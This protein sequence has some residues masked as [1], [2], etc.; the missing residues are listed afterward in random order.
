M[1]VTPGLTIQFLWLT[2]DSVGWTTWNLEFGFLTFKLSDSDGESESL[3]LVP[4]ALSKSGSSAGTHP[5][6][7]LPDSTR[8]VDRKRK[9]AGRS[10]KPITSFSKVTIRARSRSHQRRV[11][12][13][14]RKAGGSKTS[15]TVHAT[16]SQTFSLVTN[17]T[18]S[19]LQKTLP[20]QPFLDQCPI[21]YIHTPRNQQELFIG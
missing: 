17:R 18:N 1:C 2:F 9:Q 7:T 21:T 15:Y 8:S 3:R 12:E 5:N 16:T 4:V 20:P 11:A 10:P 6:W 14:E 19:Y 13:S